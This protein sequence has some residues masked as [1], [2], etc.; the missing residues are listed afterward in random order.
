MDECSVYGG[1][2]APTLILAAFLILLIIGVWVVWM[3]Q[4]TPKPPSPPKP[5]PSAPPKAPAPP[6]G[7]SEQVASWLGVMKEQIKTISP[8]SPSRPAQPRRFI[9]SSA[10][11]SE[12]STAPHNALDTIMD[13]SAAHIINI[14]KRYEAEVANY[15]EKCKKMIEE[16]KK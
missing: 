14:V 12:P 1:P 11:Q 5:P 8:S 13:P 10:H 4:T 9:S 16:P 15:A 3:A 7:V 2:S 6:G